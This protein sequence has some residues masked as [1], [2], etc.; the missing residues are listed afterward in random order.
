MLLYIADESKWTQ[1]LW[2]AICDIYLNYEHPVL[3]SSGS[4]V[5]LALENHSSE[6]MHHVH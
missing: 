4:P 6:Y 3:G 5:G 1:L 2:E